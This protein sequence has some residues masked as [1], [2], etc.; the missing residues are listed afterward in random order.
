ME[1]V[2]DHPAVQKQLEQW[3]K[4]SGEPASPEEAPKS[5]SMS[6]SS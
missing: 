3:K 1:D 6:W 5:N 4:D 2:Q